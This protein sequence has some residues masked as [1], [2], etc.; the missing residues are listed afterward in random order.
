LFADV[1]SDN[2]T[3][4]SDIEI[5]N[6]SYGLLTVIATIKNN[7]LTDVETDVKF[8]YI[9][10]CIGDIVTLPVLIGIHHVMVL[11]GDIIKVTQFFEGGLGRYHFSVWTDGE[12]LGS[13]V[14]WLFF[15]GLKLN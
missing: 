7:G 8:S 13:D 15:I 4:N 11:A 10:Y 2:S 9:K 1:E 6:I 12:S 14:F 3:E 5:T